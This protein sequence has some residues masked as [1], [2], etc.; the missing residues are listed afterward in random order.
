MQ[1]EKIAREKYEAKK[2]ILRLQA[3]KDLEK[4]MRNKD[5]RIKEAAIDKMLKIIEDSKLGTEEKTIAIKK[6]RKESERLLK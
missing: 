2:K 5:G 4:I 3:E 1:N 6:I